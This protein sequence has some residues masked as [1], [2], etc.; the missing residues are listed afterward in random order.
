MNPFRDWFL[1]QPP[2]RLASRLRTI[3]DVTDG[4]HPEHPDLPAVELGSRCDRCGNEPL[5]VFLHGH[6][7]EL[8]LCRHDANDLEDPLESAGWVIALDRRERTADRW[9]N[10]GSY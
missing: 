4:R 10:I 3:G 1:S 8:H 2:P 5:T 9:R 6:D 7:G